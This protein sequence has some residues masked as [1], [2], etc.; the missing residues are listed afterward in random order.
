MYD[1]PSS[2]R[3]RADGARL[4]NVPGVSALYIGWGIV[5]ALTLSLAV[6]LAFAAP[7]LLIMPAVLVGMGLVGF[8]D[9]R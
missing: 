4:Q 3:C 1:S 5:L 6:S 2:S 8:L 7:D 9:G